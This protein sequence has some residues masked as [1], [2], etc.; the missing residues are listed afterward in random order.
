MYWLLLPLLQAQL[1]VTA[2]AQCS[3]TMHTPTGSRIT[4]ADIRCR[5]PSMVSAT[6]HRSLYLSQSATKT[7]SLWT[8]CSKRVGA[9]P[10]LLTFCGADK[11]TLIVN[12]S[13]VRR[14]EVSGALCVTDSASVTIQDSIASHNLVKEGGLI[15]ARDSAQIH[16]KNTSFSNNRAV[17]GGVL[18]AHDTA[19]VSISNCSFQGN[20]AS[21]AGGAVYLADEASAEV[22]NSTYE[23]NWTL[24]RGG[25]ISALDGA[26]A[27][28]VGATFLRN[29]GIQRPD[30]DCSGARGGAVFASGTTV[31]NILGTLFMENSLNGTAW[32]GGGAISGIDHASITLEK[33]DFLHN[34]AVDRAGAVHA[35][36]FSS[37]TLRGCN[38]RHNQVTGP[39]AVGAALDGLANATY[40]VTDCLFDGN[41]NVNNFG[42]AANLNQNA[43]MNVRDS[44]FIRNVAEAGP[45]AYV[46]DNSSFTLV[47]CTMLEN[48]AEQ[49]GGAVFAEGDASRITVSSSLCINNTAG[50]SAGC[51]SAQGRCNV[52][53]EQ[54]TF[55]GN[56][57]ASGGALNLGGDVQV[58]LN[59]VIIAKN[60]WVLSVS[61]TNLYRRCSTKG[62]H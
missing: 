58:V 40:D 20:H 34:V 37:I 22:V 60:R 30:E 28:I 45:V 52:Y 25:A 15:Q 35:G 44:R 21:Q 36:N 12:I 43:T 24:K 51:L 29:K 61:T 6:V 31:I 13:H 56:T 49:W 11:I 17:L 8:E 39:N 18:S 1:L 46:S 32:S 54:S 62:M 19:K 26:T 4:E 59:N 50:A 10:C 38:F 2:S 14:D 57:A 33:C 41:I 3:I 16:L 53:I 48:E 47:N 23:D 7:V 42:G 55:E 27:K 9:A 5:T